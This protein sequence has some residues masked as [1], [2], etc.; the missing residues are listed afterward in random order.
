M[1]HDFL[2][3]IL[4]VFKFP[5]KLATE[6]TFKVTL[7]SSHLGLNQFIVQNVFPF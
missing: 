3:I 2:Q 5:G 4:F 7:K 6:T 1:I